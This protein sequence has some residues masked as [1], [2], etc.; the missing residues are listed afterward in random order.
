MHYESFASCSP[1]ALFSAYRVNAK[2][3]AQCFH[4]QP[5]PET[6]N[7]L[8][9]AR[10]DAFATIT[11]SMLLPCPF[12]STPGISTN[13]FDRNSFAQSGFETENRANFNVPTRYPQALPPFLKLPR[14]P[15]P[16]GYFNPPDQSVRPAS[17]QKARFA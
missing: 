5:E 10:N 13:P 8:S 14:S 6:R 4:I 2:T 3:S 16:F 12:A 17:L 11:R 1:T 15:L 7:G 9:L